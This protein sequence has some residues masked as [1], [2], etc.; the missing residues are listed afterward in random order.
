MAKKNYLAKNYVALSKFFFLLDFARK[1]KNTQL[2]EITIASNEQLKKKH[3]IITPLFWLCLF[4]LA[5]D[6]AVLEKIN[7]HGI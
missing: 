2:L 5:K 7:N 6:N 1:R 3:T 4:Y